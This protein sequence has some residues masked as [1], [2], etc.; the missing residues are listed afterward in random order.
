MKVIYI[1]R[2]PDGVKIS[3]TDNFLRTL[4]CR[5]ESVKKILAHKYLLELRPPLIHAPPTLFDSSGLPNLYN[6]WPK[7]K[8]I[9]LFAQVHGNSAARP[10]SGE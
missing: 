6:I 5:S 3:I 4:F 10:P 1:I 8:N 2:A 7:Y 9:S